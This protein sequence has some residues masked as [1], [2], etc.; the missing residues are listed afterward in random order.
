[1]NATA[2]AVLTPL[3]ILG[4]PLTDTIMAMIRRK[5]N[6]QSIATADKRHLHH[7]LMALG[8]THRGAVLV[9]YGIA[10]IFAFISI[11]LQFSSRIGGI[12]LVIAC[13]F[14]LEIFIELV[15]ILGE[16]RQ[17]VLK[18]LKF[19]GNSAYRD[20]V[21]HPERTDK[22]DNKDQEQYSVVDEEVDEPTQEFP[23]QN[24]RRSRH[25]K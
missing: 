15:G 2:V 17:P 14:G 1:K 9:I 23:I 20:E 11:L 6:R 18:A 24:Y 13:L 16:N 8:F 25:K 22:R 12:L 4:V 21:L 19:V 7:R 3:L 10:S 5:L